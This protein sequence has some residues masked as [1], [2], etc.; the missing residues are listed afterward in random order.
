M[1]KLY[2]QAINSK[3]ALE[4]IELGYKKVNILENIDLPVISKILSIIKNDFNFT[5]NKNSYCVLEKTSNEGHKW[6]VDT[7]SNNHMAWCQVGA[8][9][10]I[11]S[12]KEEDVVYYKDEEV[13][14]F[15]YDMVAHSSD[16]EHMVKGSDNRIVYLIFI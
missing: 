13:I 10:L 15:K 12:K 14:R 8:S 3:D 6:H 1:R 4:L 7:G 2:K 9:I 16:V 11:D 5:V